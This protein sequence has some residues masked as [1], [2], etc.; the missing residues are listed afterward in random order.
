MQVL[1][2]YGELGTWASTPVVISVGFFDG[3]HRGHQQ[4]IQE[5]RR[6]AASRQAVSLLITFSN[7]PR[8]FH[9]PGR[10]WKFLT[11]PEEKLYALSRTGVDAVLMLR[12]DE[13]ICRQSAAMFLKGL[14]HFVDLRAAVFGYDTSIGNDLVRGETALEELCLSQEI[15]YRV[16]PA[17]S[18]N[19]V[20]VKSSL[21]R[22]LVTKG[23]VDEAAKL[24]GH[25]YFVLSRVLHGRGQGQTQLAIPTANQRLA[26]D[27][28]APLI[29]I[30]AGS[31]MIGREYLPAAICVM[32]VACVAK[33]TAIGGNEFY[34]KDDPTDMLVESHILDFSGDI[35]EQVIRLDF[36]KRIRDWENFDNPEELRLRM[37]EDI[38]ITRELSIEPKAGWEANP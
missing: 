15:G 2:S 35:Y 5:L 8:Q 23:Q 27:K 4:L 12:Y 13:S 30:Y 22:N 36:H 14:Q 32:S 31:A 11:T 18:A 34:D 24:M 20:T 10:Q 6:E 38:R 16:V 3:V 1:R 19:G 9:D 28:L 17:Y 26:R 25:P 21:L 29:G 7:S 37:Q 33:S